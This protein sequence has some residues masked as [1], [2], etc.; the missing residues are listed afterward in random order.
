MNFLTLMISCVLCMTAGFCL[1]RTRHVRRPFL[2]YGACAVAV[3]TAA[4]LTFTGLMNDAAEQGPV[5]TG[6]SAGYMDFAAPSST[7]ERLTAQSNSQGLPSVPAMIQQLESRLEAAPADARGW[8]LLAKS[9]AYIGNDN[10]VEE[11]ITNAVRLGAEENFLRS[12]VTAVR[13]S[14]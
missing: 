5:A 1:V 7:N 8:S 9:Y 12:Q 4:T 3:A 13:R 2:A 10:G 11:A 6:L 14:R